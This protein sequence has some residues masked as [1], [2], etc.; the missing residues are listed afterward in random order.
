M[1]GDKPIIVRGGGEMGSAVARLLFLSGLPV[2]VLE[3]ERPLAVR[4]LVS[5]AEAIVSGSVT[6]EGVTGR[7]LAVGELGAALEE[8][9]GVAVAVDPEGESLACLGPAALVDARMAK[10]NIGTRLDQAGV[11]VGLGPGFLAGEDVHA[12]IETQR[13]PDL[14]R[15]VWAGSAQPDTSVP[16]TVM[17]VGEAR[18]LRAPRS[19]TFRGAW[20][21]GE[22]VLPGSKVGE[23]DG[24]PVHAA[25]GG[26]VRGLLA[27]G[28]PVEAGT[29]VGDIDPRGRT[30]DPARI[31][32]KG[33]SVAAGALEAVLAL[34]QGR[35]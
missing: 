21:I 19:G 12:V 2:A 32:D 3:A 34:L 30:V 26:M 7:R 14:G 25:V 29:K 22:L 24:E 15:V 33:R 28:V 8:A 23:V 11:V 5:F 4:R 13:G 9:D 31:S 6:V 1:F 10:R 20:R 35:A 17:G 18:V 27:D 16:G